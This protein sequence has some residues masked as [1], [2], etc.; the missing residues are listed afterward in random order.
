[1]LK[2]TLYRAPSTSQG[3][4][5]A[6][7]F[8][9]TVRYS[10]E[11]PWKGNERRMSC[12]PLGVYECRL[13]RSPRFG[14]IYSVAD[15]PGRSSVRIHAANF[16]GDSTLGWQTELEGCI[17]P[18]SRFG[19]MRNKHGYMQ[20]AGLLSRPALNDLTLWAA[21]RPFTLEIQSC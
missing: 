17:A 7:I 3:T 4:F 13:V 9:T 5:G 21:G 14:L 19:T 18:C 8:G 16:A 10:L 12:I 15:V 2:C 6:L 1:M 11:L 20:M